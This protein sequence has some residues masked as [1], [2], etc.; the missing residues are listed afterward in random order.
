MS[1]LRKRHS[2]VSLAF[3]MALLIVAVLA[4][5][6]CEGSKTSS[7]T[8]PPTASPSPVV[9]TLPPDLD[10]MFGPATGGVGKTIA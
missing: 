2:G 3:P 1:T 8:T 9:T 4:L 5:A 10:A 6:A 7:S